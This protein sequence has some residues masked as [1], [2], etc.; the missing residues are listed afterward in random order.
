M[1]DKKSYTVFWF[2]KQLNEAFQNRRELLEKALPVLRDMF[3]LDRVYFFDWQVDRGILS[4]KMMCK[5]EYCMDMQEDIS[6]INEPDFLKHLLQKGLVDS[7]LSYPAV[8]LLLKWQR[9]AMDLKD[10]EVKTSM[11]DKIGVLRLERFRKNRHFTE[12]ERDLLKSLGLEISHNLTNTEIDQAKNQSLGVATALND[13]A[14]IF[15]SSLRLT[16]GLELILQGVQRYFRFDR[17]RLYL[18]N[19]DGTKIKTI[20]GVDISGEVTRENGDD[21]PDNEKRLL[22]DVFDGGGMFKMMQSV[23]YIPLRVQ[24]NKVGFLTFDNLLSRRKIG[25]L[26]YLSLRQFATQIALS[27]DN[28]ALFERVQELSNYDEL[29]KLPVRRFFNEKF[30]EE[31][32]RSKRFDLTMSLMILDIDL[33]KQ[34]NDNYGH[35]IGDYALKEISKVIRTSLRQTDFPCRYGGDEMVIMLPRT[36]GEEAQIIAKRLKERVG[37]IKIPERYTD[38]KDVRL[39]ISQG[40]ATFPSDAQDETELFEKADKALYWVKNGHRGAYAVYRDIADQ[41]PQEKPASN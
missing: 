30:K 2:H 5:E 35:Q 41:L 32:Y 39:S 40:I 28:A 13:L 19:Y 20:L 16:D 24:R 31:I 6:L 15:A 21:L 1:L 22:Q 14:N 7:D 33:F 38:G 17:V 26:D 29:T 36:N 34:I 8:Y 27:I 18:T 23:M 11:Q 9:P 4:L 10:G 12:S 37:A 3:K 25:F